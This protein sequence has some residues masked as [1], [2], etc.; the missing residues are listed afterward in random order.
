MG[1]WARENFSGFQLSGKTLGI[2]G[3][4][5]LGKI[6]ARIGLGFGMQV[7]ANDIIDSSYTGIKMVDFNYLMSNSDIL[8]IHVHLNEKTRGMIN[9]SALSLMKPN[10]IIVNTSRGAIISE[11]DL[12][13]FL[14]AGKIQGAALD[15]IDG[16]WLKPEKLK[17][18]PLIQY[19][20]KNQNLIITPHI[21]GST[22]ESIK[23]SRIFMS[24]KIAEW[25]KNSM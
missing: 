10:C 11:P 6:S 20:N 5:R 14:T 23:Y 9:K 12:L 3:L 13:N 1:N 18:H 24:K 15:I 8:T 17:K 4:G 21:G 19:A 16:E 2:L 22:Q 7:I 25:I